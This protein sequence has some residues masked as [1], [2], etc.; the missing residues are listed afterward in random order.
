[1]DA[2]DFD[3]LKLIS[4]NSHFPEKMLDALDKL[5]DN[6]EKEERDIDYKDP[7]EDRSNS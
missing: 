3:T 4:R 1:M 7:D 6:W 2:I 5:R